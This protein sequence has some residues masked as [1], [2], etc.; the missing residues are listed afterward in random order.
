MLQKLQVNNSEWIRNSSQ[1]SE[2]LTNVNSEERHEGNFLEVDLQYPE[3]FVELHDDLPF[4]QKKWK[5]KK[6]KSLLLIYII[7][8]NMLFT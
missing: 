1:V 5:S 4:Y 7:A 2:D 6:L 3:K 8:L